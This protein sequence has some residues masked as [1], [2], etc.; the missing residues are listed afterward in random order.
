MNKKKKVVFLVPSLGMGGLE[1]VLVNYANLFIARNYDVTVLN[2][3]SDDPA[4]VQ[5]LDKKVQYYKC[6]TP[7]PNLIHAKLKDILSLNIRLFPLEKWIKKHSAR[8]LHKKYIKEK[9]DIEI[10]FSGRLTLKIICG[11]TDP[12]VTKLG[13]IHGGFR[14]EIFTPLGEAQTRRIYDEVE[15]FICVSED[16]KD[17][18]Q[19]VFGRNEKVYVVNNPNDSTNI[20]RLAKEPID[21]SKDK[22]TFVSIVRFD[23]KQKRIS[24][25][26]NA[27]KRLKEEGFKFD[28]WLVGD[29]GDFNLIKSMIEDYQLDNI[30][31]LGKQANPYNYVKTADMYL[32]SSFSEGFSM[33]MMEAVILAT[34]MLTTDVPGAAE[35]LDGG[36]Y[37]MIVENSEEGIYKGMYD[38][39]TQPELFKHYQEMAELRKDYLDPEVLMDKLESIINE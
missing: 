22:F 25:L 35:M 19:K 5:H 32:C 17:T 14:Q 16:A 20:R 18:I 28:V 37:G 1:R 15:K 26:V 34:P 38:I 36:K 23:E 39:L 11:C 8:Y 9:Y 13:W 33:S 24:R 2:F 29:G 12:G 3:T 7:V 10:A 27:C 21:I 31:L 30:K 4:I 6:Y